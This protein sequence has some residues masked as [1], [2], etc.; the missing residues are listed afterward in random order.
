MWWGWG[1]PERAKPL[2]EHALQLLRDTLD[3]SSTEVSDP[4]VAEDEVRLGSRGPLDDNIAAAL[5]AIVGADHVDTSGHERLVHAGGKST[6]DLVRRRDGDAV[7]APDAVVFPG[8]TAEVAEVLALCVANRIAVVPFGGGTSVVG[9]V[10]P[11]RAAFDTLVCLDL[12]R[13]AGLID[14]DPVS[15]T[16]RFHAGTRGPAVEAALSQHGFTLGHL[17]QSHQ[18]ATIGGYAATRSAGQASTGYGRSDEL[19][20][21]LRVETPSGPIELGGHAPASAAGPDLLQL[22]LGSEGVLGVITEVTVAIVPRPTRKSYGAWAFPSFEAGVTALRS[23]I[24]DAPRGDVPDVCR[25]SDTEETALTLSLSESSSVA[26]LKRYLSARGLSHPALALFVWEGTD[27]SVSARRRRI[28][29][30][31]RRAGGVFITGIPAKSWDNGRFG[32]PYQRDELLGRGVFVETLETAALWSNLTHTHDAVQGAIRRALAGGG[33]GDDADH[34]AP[35]PRPSHIQAHVSHVYRSGASL[36]YTFIAAREADPIAQ[37]ERVKAA[38]SA[39]IVEAGATITHHHAV[40]TEHAPYL[41]AEI[42]P[43]GVELLL[44]LKHSVDPVGILNPGKLIPR[45]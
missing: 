28:A 26:T 39:A 42:G 23:V 13:M 35:L 38:A 19:I 25:L 36:Y 33:G 16:A 24:Q 3:L 43:L 34:D 1:D 4:P 22:F 31:L 20:Q 30:R 5:R 40:G 7:D 15:R 21:G 18:Q 12:G 10:E 14:L 37:Y 17:P 29:R 45:S 11:I 2:T 44:A 8:S 32:A 9:G 6:P 41:A 27:G